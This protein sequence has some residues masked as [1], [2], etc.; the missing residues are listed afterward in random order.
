MLKRKS[1]EKLERNHNLLTD[2]ICKGSK[3]IDYHFSQFVGLF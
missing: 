1:L 2:K 3:A